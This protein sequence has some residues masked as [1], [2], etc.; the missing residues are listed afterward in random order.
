MPRMIALAMSVVIT[1]KPTINPKRT[2]KPSPK[3]T[4]KAGD[5]AQKTYG[6]I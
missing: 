6:P 3:M 4:Q 5:L 2:V 1:M